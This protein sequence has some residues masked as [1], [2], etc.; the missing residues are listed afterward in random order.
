MVYFKS[1]LEYLFMSELH[2]AIPYELE[3]HSNYSQ[4]ILKIWFK[5][6]GADVLDNELLG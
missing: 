1:W 6:Y 5:Q 3:M 4:Q 2:E